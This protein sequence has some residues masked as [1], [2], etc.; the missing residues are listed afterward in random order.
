MIFY[1]SGCGNSRFVAETIADKLNE[2]LLFIPEETHKETA[3]QLKQ[4]E[5]L[6]FVFPVYAWAPP[7]FISKFISG[8]KFIGKPSYTYIVCTYGDECGKTRE[9]LSDTLKKAGLTMDAFFGVQMPETYINLPGFKL[10]TVENEKKKIEAAKKIL[11]DI[12]NRIGTREKDVNEMTVGPLP[13]LKSYLIKP[14]FYATLISDRPF[15]VEETCTGCGICVKSCSFHNIELVNERPQW[16]HHCIG[17]MSCYH[18]CPVNAINFG[19][20]TVGKGQYYF[21]RNKKQY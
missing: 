11:P 5:S 4:D 10:D 3:Y 15:R 7:K 21:G 14:L 1:F 13:V 6:G 12:C 16:K 2:T 8:L 20:A 18:H 9:I 17:C 19:N